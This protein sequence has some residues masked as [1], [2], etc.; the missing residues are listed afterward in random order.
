MTIFDDLEAEEDTLQGILDGLDEAQWVSPS[1][2]AGWTVADVV[3]TPIVSD[4]RPRG[5]CPALAAARPT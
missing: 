4:A 3:L 5:S 2:A 1:G